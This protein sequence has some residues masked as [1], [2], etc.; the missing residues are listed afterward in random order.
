MKKEEKKEAKKYKKASILSPESFPDHASFGHDKSVA[1]AL[2]DLN[3]SEVIKA[4]FIPKHGEG[5]LTI[6]Y[7]KSGTEKRLVIGYNEL[8]DWIDYYGEK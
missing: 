1:K 5:G 4:G 8:G 6:D 2:H 7:K 3:G